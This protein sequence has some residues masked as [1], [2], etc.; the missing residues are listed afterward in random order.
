MKNK[1]KKIIITLLIILLALAIALI[2][3]LYI[4][5]ENFRTWTD[6]KILHKEVSESNL[7]KIEIEDEKN[8][9]VYAYSNKVVTLKDN[10]LTFYNSSGKK[11]TEINIQ[12]TNPS[13]VSKGDYLLIADIGQSDMYLIYNES[14]QWEKTTEGNISEATVNKNGAVGVVI[15]GTVYKSVIVMYDVAGNEN[16]KTYLSETSAVDLAISDNAKYL[17]FAEIDTSGIS[18]ISTIKVISVDKAKNSPNDAIIHAYE[19]S[20]NEVALKVRFKK[21]KIVAQSDSK[22]SLF[23]EENQDKIYD[24]DKNTLF[25]DINLDGYISYLK[26]NTENLVDSDYILKIVNVDTKKEN[27]YLEK[28][29]I[30]SMSCTENVIALNSGTEVEFIRTNGILIKKYSSVKNIKNIILTD[31]IAA[32]IYKDSIEIVSL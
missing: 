27:T 24:I 8:V 20:P 32:I 9:K 30:K 15:T 12:V 21:N 4:G 6:R 2:M 1:V 25:A 13:F 26:E 7:P 22:I 23:N 28:N 17:C 31:K 18:I 29:T 11:D 10:V 14:L 16:F 5:N 19:L 3:G